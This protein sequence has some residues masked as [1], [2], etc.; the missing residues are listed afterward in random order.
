M[1]LTIS[2]QGIGG[3]TE[4]DFE[5]GRCKLTW[6]QTSLRERKMLRD[7]IRTAKDG[8][9][10]T[11]SVDEHGNAD[12]ETSRVPGTIFNRNGTLIIKGDGKVIEL[13]AKNL[14]DSEK[15]SGRLVM[16]AQPDNTWKIL[17]LGEKFDE[18]E[19]STA[20]RKVHSTAK[21]DGG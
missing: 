12:K 2:V 11:F 21:Q 14:V 5:D 4:I 13:I 1:N 6:K 9:A 18:K 7:M 15:S 20:K 3:H 17:R 16:E 8:G 19:K 10:K